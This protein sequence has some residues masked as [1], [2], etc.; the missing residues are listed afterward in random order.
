MSLPDSSAEIAPYSNRCLHGLQATTAPPTE[1]RRLCDSFVIAMG[2]NNGGR[3]NQQAETL[4]L[5]IPGDWPATT[6]KSS[7]KAMPYCA[8]LRS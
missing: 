3:S 6:V 5:T 2:D 8:L 7:L 1:L 4:P